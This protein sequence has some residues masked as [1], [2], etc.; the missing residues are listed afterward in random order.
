MAISQ[1]AFYKYSAARVLLE[2]GTLTY[3][4]D[5]AKYTFVDEEPTI[6]QGEVNL[7][8]IIVVSPLGT[9]GAAYYPFVTI[10]TPHNW[11]SGLLAAES[12]SIDVIESG[13]ETTYQ[14][15]KLDLGL[16]GQTRY[17]GLHAFVLGYIGDGDYTPLNGTSYTVQD[18]VNDYDN[19]EADVYTAIYAAIDATY[20]ASVAA[21]ELSKLNVSAIV[22][23]SAETPDKD[24]A[25]NSAAKTAELAVLKEDAANKAIAFSVTPANVKFPTEKLVKDNLNLKE[26]LTNKK[27]V[28]STSDEFY[29]T[30]KAV[31]TANDLKADQA[32]TYTKIEVDNL[33][34]SVYKF[35]GSVATY[36]DLEAKEATAVI[37]DVWNVTDTGI[38]YAWTGA[39]WDDIGGIEALATATENGLMSKEDF[40]KLLA[41][42]TN[43][44]LN[45]LLDDKVDKDYSAY[46]EHTDLLDDDEMIIRSADTTKKV[47]VSTIRTYAPIIEYGVRRVYAPTLQSSP[48]LERVTKVNGELFVGSATNLTFNVGIDDAV[49]S[50]SFDDIDIYKYDEVEVNGNTFIRYRNRFTKHE[51]VV[52]GATTYEY[53]WQCGKKLD[54]YSTVVFDRNSLGEIDYAYIG[55]YMASDVAGVAKSKPDLYPK[56]SITRGNARISARKNDGDGT[57]TDSKYGLVDLPENYELMFVPNLI[58][59]ATMNSQSIL[60]GVVD[61]TFSG[62]AVADSTV[63]KTVIISNAEAT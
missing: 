3:D 27:T 11:V 34:A 16:I 32:T 60:R 21:L 18:G 2:R 6:N 43:T 28:L 49:V 58:I 30:V 22:G 20:A 54:G 59:T 41:L 53:Y 44:A 57:N 23:T 17:G 52:D 14:A 51:Y 39:V 9:Y 13:V 40:S 55:K 61:L 7:T 45:L 15:A 8:Q 56:V 19:I 25:V 42:P 48:T 29:P 35:K 1:Y 38:N 5:T 33:V 50:N 10:V 46:T 4:S 63:D 31:K 24:T 62:T 47:K 12:E 36:T 37:G 26:D